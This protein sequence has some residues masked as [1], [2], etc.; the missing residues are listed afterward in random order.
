[1]VYFNWC[2]VRG[3]TIFP[4]E[5]KRRLWVHVK[6]ALLKLEHRMLAVGHV[7]SQKT[8]FEAGYSCPQKLMHDVRFELTRLPSGKP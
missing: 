1:M 7:E 4:Y 6:H 2:S 5:L 8:M 3:W